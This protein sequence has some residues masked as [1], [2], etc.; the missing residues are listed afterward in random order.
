MCRWPTTVVCM[1]YS[2]EWQTEHWRIYFQCLAMSSVVSLSVSNT[3]DIQ[4]MK[5]TLVL[6]SCRRSALLLSLANRNPGSIHVNQITKKCIILMIIIILNE[7][8]KQI[9]IFV[10]QHH[11]SH[12]STIN[13][14]PIIYYESSHRPSNVSNFTIRQWNEKQ[15]SQ[16]FQIKSS[17][18]HCDNIVAFS[19]TITLWVK[20]IDFFMLVLIFWF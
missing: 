15:K 5:F 16:L 6:V 10:M 3:K 12:S 14:L 19:G 7:S 18:F 2:S 11:S 17:Q 13:R 8:V 20:C 4:K 9:L 1:L